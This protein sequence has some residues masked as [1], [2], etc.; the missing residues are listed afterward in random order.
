MKTGDLVRHRHSESGKTGL[1]IK[2]GYG[3]CFVAWLDGRLSWCV[4]SLLEVV[5]DG[6]RERTII[7]SGE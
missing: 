1:V 4:F 5:A 7:E 3:K 2:R 6:A